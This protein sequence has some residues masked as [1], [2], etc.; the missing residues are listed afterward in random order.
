MSPGKQHPTASERTTFSQISAADAGQTHKC[1]SAGVCVS[2]CVFQCT[3]G[4]GG[5][6]AAKSSSSAAGEK[7]RYDSIKRVMH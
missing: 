5:T 7:K 4:E 3:P 1:V 2:M 6:A